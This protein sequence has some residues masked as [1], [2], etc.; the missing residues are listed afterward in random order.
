M[1]RVLGEKAY[2]HR[3]IIS[4]SKNRLYRKINLIAIHFA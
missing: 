3:K 2:I 1:G 4:S